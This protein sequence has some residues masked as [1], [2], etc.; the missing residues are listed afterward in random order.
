MR[1]LGRISWRKD[2]EV[3]ARRK[4]T[5]TEVLDNRFHIIG[6]LSLASS[7]EA[8]KAELIR[9]KLTDIRLKSTLEYHT[10][11]GRVPAPI[12]RQENDQPCER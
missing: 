8:V 12:A 10:Y 11:S 9:C 4:V 5:V 7:Q 6:E 1:V 3:V 2:H